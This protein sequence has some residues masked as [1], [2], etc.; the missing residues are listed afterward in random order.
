MTAVSSQIHY[1][2]AHPLIGRITAPGRQLRTRSVPHEL[3]KVIRHR[4]SVRV[5]LID[6]GRNIVDD[7][8]YIVQSKY[9][10]SILLYR[11]A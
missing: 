1:V 9:V 2:I 5:A 10:L 3:R 7:L 6:T 4:F 8:D 11:F